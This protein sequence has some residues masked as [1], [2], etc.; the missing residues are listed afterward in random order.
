MS[1]LGHSNIAILKLFHNNAYYLIIDIIQWIIVNILFYFHR[2]WNYP[3][4]NIEG[5]ITRRLGS[6]RHCASR[7]KHDVLQ[8][9]VV[10]NDGV[11]H[12]LHLFG[13]L[14]VQENN[15]L[16]HII[17]V[18]EV[19]LSHQPL[20]V[21]SSLQLVPVHVVVDP[22]VHDVAGPLR[23]ALDHLDDGDD[24]H[25]WSRISCWVWYEHGVIRLVLTEVGEDAS[26]PG[27]DGFQVLVELMQD[28]LRYLPLGVQ[29]SVGR[30]YSSLRADTMIP[31]HSPVIHDHPLQQAGHPI[32]PHGQAADKFIRFSNHFF[33][34][35]NFFRVIRFGNHLSG[36]IG[37]GHSSGVGRHCIYQL[38]F[39]T[40]FI[41]FL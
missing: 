8:G 32:L 23:H 27:L 2:Q 29:D 36:I 33:S 5:A 7:I 37:Q 25:G 15:S 39:L 35:L 19:L 18:Q 41:F 3:T 31:D 40:K 13:H 28:W 22:G 12:G 30:N 38:S 16:T 10:Q 11:Q 14:T 17:S 34:F 24:L 21:N 20:D 1:F 4:L 26:D 9:Y 6:I